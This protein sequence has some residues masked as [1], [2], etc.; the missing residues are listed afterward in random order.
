MCVQPAADGAR[1]TLLVVP[2]ASRAGIVGEH[3]DALRLKVA[4]PPEKGRA[5]DA[6]V[7]LL[8]A[9]IGVRRAEIEITA[10]HGSRRKTAVVRGLTAEVVRD[11]L[12][13]RL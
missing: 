2:G 9:T 11:R 7:E 5:N 4:A 3:G 13:I 1:L 12:G 8:A 10:G 6:V